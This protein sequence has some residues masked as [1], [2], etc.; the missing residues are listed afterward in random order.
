[1]FD[2]LWFSLRVV[3]A[4]SRG[5]VFIKLRS[6]FLLI[7]FSRAFQWRENGK[8]YQLRI[9]FLKFSRARL[10]RVA[11][12]LSISIH[13]ADTEHSIRDWLLSLHLHGGWGEVNW[14]KVFLLPTHSRL[15]ESTRNILHTKRWKRKKIFL[16]PKNKSTK[17]NVLSVFRLEWDWEREWVNETETFCLINFLNITKA[18]G[19]TESRALAVADLYVFGN[20]FEFE[21]QL[22]SRPAGWWP[23]D[24][25][26]TLACNPLSVL[27]FPLI[28]VAPKTEERRQVEVGRS[29]IV[30]LI[31]WPEV[32]AD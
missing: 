5:S 3:R 17:E 8:F 25:R 28:D 7:A 21:L 13:R 6:K 9:I 16:S 23:A 27:V 4:P 11:Q 12:Y 32:L 22:M 31:N 20:V 10:V 30:R 18:L 19:S 2:L 29:L 24:R 1:M 14:I 15:S 26:H